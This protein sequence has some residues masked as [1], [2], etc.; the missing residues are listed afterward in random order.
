MKNGRNILCKQLAKEFSVFKVT[1]AE[2]IRE[3]EW[4]LLLLT[5]L[6]LLNLRVPY[7]FCSL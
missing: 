5:D 1:N 4:T 7:L 3:A 6:C 2:K